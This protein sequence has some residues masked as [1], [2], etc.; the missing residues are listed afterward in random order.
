[1]TSSRDRGLRVDSTQVAVGVEAASGEVVDSIARGP[2]TSE[3]ICAPFSNR[4]DPDIEHSGHVRGPRP[5]G[6]MCSSASAVWFVLLVGESLQ[7]GGAHSFPVMALSLR[8]PDCSERTVGRA[9]REL[10]AMR[11]LKVAGWPVRDED[12]PLFGVGRLH[13]NIPGLSPTRQTECPTVHRTG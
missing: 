1:M 9:T 10:R 2:V 7:Q 8:R 5:A 11:L 13:P 3:S 6:L 12:R 4:L